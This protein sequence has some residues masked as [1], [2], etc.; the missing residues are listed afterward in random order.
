M[1]DVIRLAFIGSQAQTR[2]STHDSELTKLQA[3][4][5]EQ[6]RIEGRMTAQNYPLGKRQASYL[7]QPVRV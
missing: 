7:K 6:R 4:E 3:F 5:F 1:T 2:L